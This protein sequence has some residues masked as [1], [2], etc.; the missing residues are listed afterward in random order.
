MEE[1]EEESRE[2]LIKVPYLNEKAANKKYTLVLDLDETLIHYVEVAME[3]QE[4]T[5]GRFLIRPGV[6]TFLKEMGK[7]Y[8]IVVFTAATQDVILLN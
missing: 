3:G 7:H 2:E 6:D 5:M 8:E 4:G 1:A